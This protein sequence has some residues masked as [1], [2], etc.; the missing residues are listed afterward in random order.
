MTEPL[1]VSLSVV[2]PQADAFAAFVERT[3][4]WW[5]NELYTVGREDVASVV[6]E[7]RTG[8][9]VY[10]RRH[11]GTEDVWGEVLDI[12]APERVVMTWAPGQPDGPPTEVEVRF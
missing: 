12:E 10:E 3:A 1:V 6:I 8:G 7:G 2:A 9:R 11:D 4:E 5:P